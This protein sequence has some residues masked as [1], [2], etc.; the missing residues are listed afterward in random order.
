MRLAEERGVEMNALN[1]NDFK[2][3][4]PS[5]EED[6]KNVWSF[7]S[8]IDKRSAAGGTSRQTVLEQI[9]ILKSI[10]E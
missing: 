4:H 3:L 8:S 6:I 10:Y 7:E 2:G 5:F 9:K 1:L